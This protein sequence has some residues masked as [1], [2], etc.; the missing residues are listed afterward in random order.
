MSTTWHNLVG[1]RALYQ[2]GI[3][4]RSCMIDSIAKY[5]LISAILAIFTSI[6]IIAY[7]NRHNRK[8]NVTIAGSFYNE[9]Y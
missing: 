9:L 5:K 7:F 1:L 2:V 8:T 6:D 3:K 4:P